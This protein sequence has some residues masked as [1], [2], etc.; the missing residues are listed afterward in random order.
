MLSAARNYMLS[1]LL[2]GRKDWASPCC[3]NLLKK[4]T[5]C[6]RAVHRLDKDYC[7]MGCHG[8]WFLNSGLKFGLLRSLA[9]GLFPHRNN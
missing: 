2:W 6:V 5:G 1:V 7:I 8:L 4:Y 3:G 9:L